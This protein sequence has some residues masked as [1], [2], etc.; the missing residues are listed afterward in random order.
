MY[1]FLLYFSYLLCV[2]GISIFHVLLMLVG[3]LLFMSSFRYFV[4]YVLLYV[5]RL[6]VLSLCLM[7]ALYSCLFRYLVI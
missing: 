6:F 7:V 1:V 4:I 2:F 5:S 3:R